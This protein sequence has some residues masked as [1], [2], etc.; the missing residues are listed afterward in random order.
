MQYILLKSRLSQIKIIPSPPQVANILSL[1]IFC[2]FDL[3]LFVCPIS[4]NSHIPNLS[5]VIFVILLNVSAL[6][7]NIFV[8]LSHQFNP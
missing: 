5:D 4:S 3:I 1:K 8:S 6:D 2:A 7:V